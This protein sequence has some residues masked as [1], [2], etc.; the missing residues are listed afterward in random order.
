[1]DFDECELAVDDCHDIAVCDNTAGSFTCT[2]NLGYTGSGVDCTDADECMHNLDNCNTHAA[3]TNTVGSF[4]CACNAGF[5]GDGLTCK[6][7]IVLRASDGTLPQELLTLDGDVLV[8]SG[9]WP[10][11]PAD[12]VGDEL[13]MTTVLTFRT[14]ADLVGGF[15][16]SRSEVTGQVLHHA[17]ELLGDR[18]LLFHYVSRGVADVVNFSLPVTVNDGLWHTLSLTVTGTVAVAGVDGLPFRLRILRGRPEDCALDCV[19]LVGHAAGP[20]RRPLVG[21]VR[22]VHLYLRRAVTTF[23]PVTLPVGIAPGP[24]SLQ[25][26][27]VEQAAPVFDGNNTVENTAFDVLQRG[28]DSAAGAGYHRLYCG[29]DQQ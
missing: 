16:F 10:V 22:Q 18:T 27:S 5:I 24:R 11:M 29:Q 6:D 28:G 1:V 4:T 9:S 12:Y 8:S 13:P 2:C 20:G 19:N 7:E 17:L 26:L 23:S 3:C 21:L 15:L 25:L 14:A